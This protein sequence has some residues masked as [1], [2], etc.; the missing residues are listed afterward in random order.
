VA[1]GA[2]PKSDDAGFCGGALPP[3]EAAVAEGAADAAELGALLPERPPLE[4]GVEELGAVDVAA[5]PK[6]PPAELA[7][8]A[9]GLAPKSEGAEGAVVVVAVPEVAF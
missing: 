8:G 5:P 1:A 3:D 4:A 9:A 6:R 7:A 2:P